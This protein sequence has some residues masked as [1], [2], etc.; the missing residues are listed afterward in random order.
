[1]D[2][3][4]EK[5]SFRFNENYFQLI[6]SAFSLVGKT[7]YD[8]LNFESNPEDMDYNY[9]AQRKKIIKQLNMSCSSKKPN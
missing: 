7:I 6:Y 8:D 9:I 5:V 3:K 2:E 4:G 1:M